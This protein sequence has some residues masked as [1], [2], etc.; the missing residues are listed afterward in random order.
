MINI[1]LIFP[2]QLISSWYIEHSKL[3]LG[4][5]WSGRVGV[6]FLLVRF[7]CQSKSELQQLL[8]VVAFLLALALDDVSQTKELLVQLP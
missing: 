4:Q 7:H 1:F 8:C 2:S 6:S 5:I 3:L